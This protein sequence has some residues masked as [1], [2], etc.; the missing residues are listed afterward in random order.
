MLREACWA[1]A[2]LSGGEV[3]NFHIEVCNIHIGYLVNVHITS[4]KSESFLSKSF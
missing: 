1:F 3:H 2:V 4:G